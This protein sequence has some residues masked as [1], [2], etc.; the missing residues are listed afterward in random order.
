LIRFI[1]PIGEQPQNLLL[2]RSL[3]IA[4]WDVC[5][6][7]V[8]GNARATVYVQSGDVIMQRQVLPICHT[9]SNHV[10]I[11]PTSLKIIGDVQGEG[12]GPISKVLNTLRSW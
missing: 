9:T 10:V 12:V 7:D 2:S 11:Y 5:T 8:N 6:T 3:I 4:R 1:L